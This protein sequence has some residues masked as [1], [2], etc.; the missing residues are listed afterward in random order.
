M[1]VEATGKPV[2]VRLERIMARVR[3][4]LVVLAA[5]LCVFSWW[6]L[7]RADGAA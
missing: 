3:W 7:A 2:D 4:L 6:S 1:S 5:S